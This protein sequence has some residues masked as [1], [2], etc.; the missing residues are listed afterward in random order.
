MGEIV[1]SHYYHYAMLCLKN[2]EP[3]IQ[4]NFLLISFLVQ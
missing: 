1:I 4:K 3:S 2:H